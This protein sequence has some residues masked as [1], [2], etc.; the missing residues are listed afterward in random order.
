MESPTRSRWRVA[1]EA[2]G[3]FVSAAPLTF[4]W[5]AL[6]ALTTLIQHSL[7]GPQLHELLLRGS[8]NLHHLATDPVRVLFSSLF[9]I[10]GRQWWPYLVVFCLFLAPA[11]HWLGALRW[12][13]VGLV[14]HIVATYIGEGALYLDIQDALASPRL[15]NARDIGVSYF[16]LGLAG[17]LTYRIARPWRWLYLA[18]FLA[19]VTTALALN[20]SF[21]SIGHFSALLIGLACY[22][23]TLGRRG[24]RRDGPAYTADLWY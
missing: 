7:T 11:E 6:L 18:A 3:H 12:L 15:I 8:T 19:A 1:T 21:T 23:L 5:L 9:W 17:V 10:D 13:G 16:V 14:A 2:I 24:P 20:P 4:S 22:P